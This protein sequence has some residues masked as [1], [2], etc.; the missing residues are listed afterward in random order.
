VFVN[1]EN[2][3]SGAPKFTKLCNLIEW[4]VGNN[5]SFGS[6][7]KSQT[8]FKLKFLEGKL[9]LN[10]NWIYWRFKYFW[11]KSDKFPKIIICPVLLECEFRLAWLYSQICSFHTSSIWLG[12]KIK[13]S[14]FEFE[15]KLNLVH[16]SLIHCNYMVRRCRLHC[17]G[18]SDTWGVTAGPWYHVSSWEIVAKHNIL[19]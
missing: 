12:L 15:F 18:Y 7:F 11:K 13:K 17:S 10:L 16:M 3:L 6:K 4:K 8:E 1:Y 19:L 9:F 5:I 2:R 14:G